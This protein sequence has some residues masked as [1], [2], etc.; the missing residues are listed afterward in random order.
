MEENQEESRKRRALFI[1]N[2]KYID[3]ASAEGG[4]KYCTAEYIN[5]I[6]TTFQVV[7]FPLD[8]KSSVLYR[9]KNRLGLNV[10]ND[11]RTSDYEAALKKVITENNIELVFLN[12]TNTILF[13][14]RIKKLFPVIKIILCSHGNESG[15][16][17]HEMVL[18]KKQRNLNS[19]MANYALG[20]MLRTES[21]YRR[22][23]DMVLTVSDIE[24]SI[25]KWLGARKAY[26]VPRS[27]TGETINYIPFPGRIG[28]FG[29]LT[30]APNYYGVNQVCDALKKM[31]V[32]NIELRLAGMGEST[33]RAIERE[34]SFVRYLGYLT[35]QQLSDEVSRWTF[36]I[37]P[38]FYYSRGVSTKLGKALS[39]GIPV[40]TSKKGMRGYKWQE[41]KILSCETAEQMASTISAFAND[42][43]AA[44]FYR[45]EALKIKASSPG[46]EAIM[47]EICEI[48]HEN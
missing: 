32:Q 35:E 8:I 12:L 31:S 3:Y 13:S 10:Y 9:I 46:Y 36:S 2:K 21:E 48:L 6:Q 23:V 5:L 15:D 47:S 4:V 41:G 37:N 17:L 26:M 38:V 14:R 29:D 45:T 34:Y 11:Y 43:C 40:I 33:G 22:Y 30:H 18:H 27:I 24:L 25:E 16:F 39:W 7:F 42:K 19:T 44:D 1:T 28:F 20:K